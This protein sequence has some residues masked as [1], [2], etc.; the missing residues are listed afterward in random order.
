MW[1]SGIPVL[2][3]MLLCFAYSLTGEQ[4]FDIDCGR[5]APLHSP[6]SEHYTIVFNTFVLMQI[7]NELNARKIHGERNVFDGMFNNPIFCSIVLG[8]LVIQ[9]ALSIEPARLFVLF[10]SRW[11]LWIIRC[12]KVDN[13]KAL[14]AASL[15]KSPTSASSATK[16]TQSLFILTLFLIL[17]EDH[18]CP[19]WWQAIQLCES[20]C[21]ALDVVPFLWHRQSP[22]GTGKNLFCAYVH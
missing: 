12:V 20:Y 14:E 15:L 1:L 18:H 17:V 2:K 4:M 6:P 9:V 13:D 5:N 16:S 21:G 3:Q 10:C 19:V 11:Q 22:V 8:T 7:F